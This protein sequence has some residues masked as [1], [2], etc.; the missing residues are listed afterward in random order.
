MRTATILCVAVLAS[1]NLAAA[2]AAAGDPD[3]A[4]IEALEKTYNDGFNTRNVDKIMSCYARGTN[5]FVYDVGPPRAYPSWEAYKKD[6]EELFAAF[7]GPVKNVISDQTITVVGTVGY[8]HNI[9]TGEITRKDGTKLP[10]VVRTT[11]IWRK[12]NGNWLIVEEHNSMPVDFG[13][14][15]ADP[16]SK[17]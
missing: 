11:D 14:M 1:A 16:L 5:L 13:T 10:V 3:K 8:G 9:Q 17:P 7:P 2:G 6:W 12:T 15:K 4:A